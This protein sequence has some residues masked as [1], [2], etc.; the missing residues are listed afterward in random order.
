M[1]GR[2]KWG[3]LR[4]GDRVR[5]KMD[6]LTG[7]IM[8]WGELT[9]CSSSTF[10]TAARLHGSSAPV[11]YEK[12]HCGRLCWWQSI[13]NLEKIPRLTQLMLWE[14]KEWKP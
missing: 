5:D 4:S 13:T 7:T 1:N 12:E 10:W 6:G 9:D 14:E 8:T 11:R 2:N 3:E